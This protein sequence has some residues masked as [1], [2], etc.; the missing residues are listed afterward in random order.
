VSGHLVMLALALILFS[1]V[2]SLLATMR[3]RQVCTR[4]G[5][6]PRADRLF[7]NVI[8]IVLFLPAWAL[9]H[10]GF[11]VVWHAEG[12]TRIVL[13]VV[14]SLAICGLVVALRGFDLHEFIGLRPPRDAGS[15]FGSRGGGP[16]AAPVLQT[17]GAYALC[18]HPLYLFT[19]LFFSAW[20]VMDFGRLVFAIWVWL[21]A[22]IGS[23][24]E[25]RRLVNVFG[26][27]YRAYQRTHWRL[28]PFGPRSRSQMG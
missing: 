15:D 18:R 27:T 16:Q 25:E 10:G 14:Q 28:L 17:G 24:F 7:Y 19:G 22:W 6:G 8:S 4:W 5:L 2:H 3:A 13:L 23:I 20:P 26:S 12:T 9:V 11:P 1:C 21:Y